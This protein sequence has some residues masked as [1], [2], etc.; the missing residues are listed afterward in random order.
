MQI[1]FDKEADALYITL[2]DERGKAGIVKR[3]ERMKNNPVV[4]DYDEDDKLYGIEIFDLTACS[5]AGFAEDFLLQ[6]AGQIPAQ[7]KTA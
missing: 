1:R 2:G 7:K 6:Y 3:S 4:L 5:R